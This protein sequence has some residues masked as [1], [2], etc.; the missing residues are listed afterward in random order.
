MEK[1]AQNP[2]LPQNDVIC[3]GNLEKININWMVLEDGT[4]IMPFLEDKNDN[5]KWRVNH[6]PSCGAYVRDCTIQP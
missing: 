1:Q 6:C 4:K 3:C 5:T 2:Q